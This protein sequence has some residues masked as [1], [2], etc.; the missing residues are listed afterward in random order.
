VTGDVLKEISAAFA[1]TIGKPEKYCQ[2]LVLPDQK[3]VMS[4][5]ADVCG[6]AVCMSI[7]KLGPEENQ[8]H[9]AALMEVVNAKLGIPKDRLYILFQDAK[10]SE[11]GWNGT[12]FQTI[13]GGD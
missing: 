1:T 13:L 9:T 2:V 8:K 4:G 7:G 11:V 6:T 12:T 3:M 5:T 10:P